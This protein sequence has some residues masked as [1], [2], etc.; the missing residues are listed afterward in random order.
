[1]VTAIDLTIIKNYLGTMNE[2]DEMTVT[3]ILFAVF[4]LLTCGTVLL[5]LR[6]LTQFLG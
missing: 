5:I 3:I 6:R 1:M 2:E 4:T